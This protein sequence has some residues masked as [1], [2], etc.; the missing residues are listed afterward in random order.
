MKVWKQN[1][2][3][4][5]SGTSMQLAVGAL[6]ASSVWFCIKNDQ[7]SMLKKALDDI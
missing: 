2:T 5:G 1:L 7:F 3:S 4:S 6:I